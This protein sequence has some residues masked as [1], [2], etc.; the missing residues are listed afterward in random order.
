ME[1]LGRQCWHSADLTVRT[2]TVPAECVQD[3]FLRLNAEFENFRKRSS[4]E[5]AEAIN[6]AK[7]NVIQVRAPGPGLPAHPASSA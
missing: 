2:N 5:K 1:A 4:K 3:K 6:K 7:S